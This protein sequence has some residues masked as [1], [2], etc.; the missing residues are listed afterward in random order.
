MDGEFLVS[1]AE[2]SNK[3][4]LEGANCTFSSIAAMKVWWD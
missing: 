4:I 2:A 3:M 1:A